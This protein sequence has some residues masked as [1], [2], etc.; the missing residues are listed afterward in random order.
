M[1]AADPLPAAL[2]AHVQARVED[3]VAGNARAGQGSDA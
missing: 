2:L 3:I 1:A